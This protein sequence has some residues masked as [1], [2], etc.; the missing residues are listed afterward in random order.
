MS[1][2]VTDELQGPH[3]ANHCIV[4]PNNTTLYAA[5]QTI[6]TVWRKFQT[7]QTYNSYNDNTSRPI[8]GL[9]VSITLKRA[10]SKVILKWWI[11]YE[12]HHDITFQAIRGGTVIG[13]NSEVGNVRYS[14]MGAADYEHSHDQSSTP[15]YQHHMWIDSPG[16]VGPHTYQIGSRSSTGSNHDIRMNRSWNG[17]SDDHEIGVSWCVVEEIAQ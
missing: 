17:P 5:G 2:L 16:S 14:G 11:F 4:M 6:Q 15:T 12:A 9:D 10:N 3:E 13:F 1:T 7:V 8:S